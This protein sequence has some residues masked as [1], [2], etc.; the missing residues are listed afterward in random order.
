MR[1][2]RKILLQNCV[3]DLM[4]I[5]SIVLYGPILVASRGF[6]MAVNNSFFPDVPIIVNFI[7]A[8][9]YLYFVS[10]SFAL[11]P[12]PFV[13]RYLVLVKNKDIKEFSY[14]KLYIIPVIVTTIH[15]GYQSVLF[16]PTEEKLKQAKTI[17][18]NVFVENGID[19]FS[20]GF[21]GNILDTVL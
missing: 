19:H 12:V 17:F 16:Y 4:L 11:I 8:F 3:I 14:L 6:Q 7:F 18:H 1:E 9:W 10:L 15:M 20:T 5:C 21:V 13:Y 2:Y